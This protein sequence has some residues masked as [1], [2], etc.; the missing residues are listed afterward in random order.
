[1]KLDLPSNAPS[2]CFFAISPS[3]DV[4]L[5]QVKNCSLSVPLPSSSNSS[6]GATWVLSLVQSL[7]FKNPVT[8]FMS[9]IGVNSYTEIVFTGTLPK[10][11][12]VYTGST[13][14]GNSAVFTCCYRKVIIAS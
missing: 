3:Q 11:S 9:H 5:A 1:M 6:A 12:Q 10:A 13:P 4:A 2:C 14:S 7:C 8:V